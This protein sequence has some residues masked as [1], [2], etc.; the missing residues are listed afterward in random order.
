MKARLKA[1]IK[2]TRAKLHKAKSASKARMPGTDER[3]R[4]HAQ[5]LQRLTTATTSPG[6]AKAR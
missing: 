1:A 4:H 5:V 2:R 6:T 3:V